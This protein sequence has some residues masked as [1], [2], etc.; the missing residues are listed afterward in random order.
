MAAAKLGKHIRP[1]EI[2]LLLVHENTNP[3]E[4][5]TRSDECRIFND[6][7]YWMS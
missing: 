6:L 3:S 4:Q 1:E 2:K 7:H 5:I